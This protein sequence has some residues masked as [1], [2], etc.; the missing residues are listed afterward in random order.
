MTKSSEWGLNINAKKVAALAVLVSVL[1]VYSVGGVAEA[2]WNN[3]CT[4]SRAYCK[5]RNG[6]KWCKYRQQ[7]YHKCSSGIKYSSK[8][9]N[10]ISK[11]QP[12]ISSVRNAKIRDCKDRVYRK[13]SRKWPKLSPYMLSYQLKRCEKR[14]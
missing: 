3:P 14:Y 13:N 8:P 12:K 2:G 4:D 6:I 1:G 9:K 10:S 5:K 11:Y 7:S